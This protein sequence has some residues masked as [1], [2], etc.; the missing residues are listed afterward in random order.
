MKLYHGTKSY[1]N[2]KIILPVEHSVRGDECVLVSPVREYALCFAGRSWDDS[3]MELSIDGD[4]IVLKEKIPGAIH[5]T[6]S[7]PGFLYMID[8]NKFNKFWVATS[9]VQSSVIVL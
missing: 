7:I 9:L 1:F 4:E 3:M 8:S 6:Y 2:S 5:R